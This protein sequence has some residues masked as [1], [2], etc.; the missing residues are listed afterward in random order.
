MYDKM[1]GTL[2]TEMSKGNGMRKVLLIICGIW[3]GLHALLHLFLCP[4]LSY[5]GLCSLLLP[6]SLWILTSLT[7]HVGRYLLLNLPTLLLYL[8]WWFVHPAYGIL[9]SIQW[10]PC[11]WICS[12][13]V[14]STPSNSRSF[15]ALLYAIAMLPFAAM[16][17]ILFSALLDI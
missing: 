2:I 3:L 13:I 14:T 10:L 17:R 5:T 1:T 7:N 4:I 11:V 12:D 15:C 6:F 8:G 16:L 9:F